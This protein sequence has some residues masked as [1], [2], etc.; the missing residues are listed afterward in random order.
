MSL[1]RQRR[2]FGVGGAVLGLALGTLSACSDDPV[3]NPKKKSS[4]G[5]SAGRPSEGEGGS[6][7]SHQGG[8]PSSPSNGGSSSP[9]AGGA[10]NKAGAGGETTGGGASGGSKSDPP[11]VTGEPPAVDSCAG[12]LPAVFTS[13]CAGCHTAQGVPNPRYPDLYQFDGSREEFERHVRDGS[14]EGMPRYSQE[15]VSDADVGAIYEYF[16]GNHSRGDAT[17][18]LGGVVPLFDPSDAVNAPIV[19]E[20]EDGVLVTRGAGRVRGRHEGP[21]DTNQPF[22]EFVADYF[23]SRTY[24]WIVED[25]TRLG[26]SKIR[27][28]YLPI[29]LPTTGTNFRAWKDYG[30]GDVFTQNTG[31]TSNA[32]L[33][34][35]LV[36]DRN[37][38]AD[39]EKQVAPYAMVQQQE[40]TRNNRDGRE[41]EV[42]DLFEFEFGIFNDEGAIQPPGSRTAY[43]TDTFRYR[44]GKGGV[45]ADN[46]DLY[47]GQGVLGPTE[48]AQ[49]GG[50]TTN[51][52]AYFMQETQFGQMALNIQH[53]NVQRFVEG[54]RL[55]HTDFATGKHSESGN[56]DFTEQRDKAGPLGISASCEGCHVHNGAGKTLSGALEMKSSMAIKLYGD[57]QAGAQLQLKDG[58]ATAS[59]TDDQTVE[60]ADGTKIVLK[61]PKIAVTMKD[62]KVP[63]FSARIA[64]KVIG[65][66]LLEAVDESEILGRADMSDCNGDGISGRANFVADPGTGELRVGRF[67]WKAE[68][69]SIEH[70]TA[71]ALHDDMGVGTSLFPDSGKTELANDDLARLVTYMR[72]V[73]VPGQRDRDDEKVR[74]GEQLFQT[75]GCA[76]CHVTDL[77]TGMN[78]PFSELRGQSIKPYSDLL[79]HD[80]GSELADDTAFGAP[81]EASAPPA[82]SEWRTPPLWGIGLLETINGNTGLLHDGRAANVLEAILWHGGEAEATRGRVVALSAADR[83]ALIAF[84]MSL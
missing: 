68:K 42:G 17:P 56:P 52:W 76:K 5:A 25:F 62:G 9:G 81:A 63:A 79:L 45:T 21:L 24:G 77:V 54:R 37:L 50:A 16:T 61:K 22:M 65:M 18:E 11:P 15:L 72:L 66:G 75:I 58:S 84:V 7:S 55:F 35:L 48:D 36:G 57:D 2:T 53:E 80:L 41:I 30:N 10:P 82:A 34:E 33:P 13:T 71:E 1:I 73:S 69:V 64:R 14:T 51:V 38:A 28:T 40:T 31:M 83:E 19:F 49:Q 74:A 26:E 6:S 39:Y 44:V 8:S 78:H 23:L 4:P 20:R 46:P 43:Y 67:G 47:N 32:D 59:G 27:V 70:Q 29:S 3:S 12:A 60:L